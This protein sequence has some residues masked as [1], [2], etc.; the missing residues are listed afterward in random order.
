MMNSPAPAKFR[1][2]LDLG[3]RQERNSV[4]TESAL[5]ALI[6][7][8]RTEGRR[9]GI[10]EGERSAT[11]RAAQRIAEAAERL[12]D[13]TA[14]LHAALDDNR[15][16]TITEAVDLAASVGRKLARHLL[17]EQPTAE[18][19]ALIADCLTSLNAVPHLVIRCHPE[20]A[21]AT[22]DI[23][24]ARIATSGFSGRLVVLGDPE[25]A[26]G[27]ARIEWSDGGIVR[28]EAKLEAEIDA[29]IQHFLSAR[30]G[31]PAISSEGETP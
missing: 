8:A 6:D 16:A 28:D 17:S 21:D 26:M 19:E 22:R 27:D 29:R 25:M 1:F 9:E 20:L 7:N 18:I 14:A 10:N 5:A 11:V 24:S 13:H 31:P 23:A 30:R 15:H 3:H 12:A 2:D 4:V